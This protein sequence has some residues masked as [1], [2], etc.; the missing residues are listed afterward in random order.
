MEIL[1]SLITIC[2]PVWGLVIIVVALFSRKISL[3]DQ[4]KWLVLPI[5]FIAGMFGYVLEP[6]GEPDLIRYFSQI[7]AI[8]SSGLIELF[9]SDKSYLYIKDALFYFVHKCGN[10]HL[11]PFFVGTFIYGIV[12]YVFTDMIQNSKNSIKKTEIIM[13]SII[14][15]GVIAPYNNIVNVRCILAYSIITYAV[16]RDLIQRKKNICTL[17]LYILPIGLHN[18]AI[19]LLL[20][21]GT[22]WLT[23]RLGR[24]LLLIAFFLPMFI[25]IG[26]R[27]TKYLGHRFLGNLLRSVINKAYYYLNWSEGGW[28]SMIERSI[29]NRLGRIYGVFFIIT[30]LVM[31]W[32]SKDVKKG[33][34]VSLTNYPMT[35]YLI[36]VSACA[37]GCLSIKTGAFWRFESILVLFS[38][39]YLIPLTECKNNIIVKFG[40]NLLYSTSICMFFLNA[41]YQI[42]NLDFYHTMTGFLFTS[43]FQV[44]YEIVKGIV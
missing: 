29:S 5:A 34:E 31:L 22:Y 1:L 41:V 4:G 23:K 14:I 2:Y 3:V 15:I 27:Y 33:D 30:I 24:V 42:R 37:L 38:P 18:S 28:A 16:Y 9:K 21:R 43:G 20:I 26:Y 19:V 40:F 11:L 36:F 35:N 13:M 10:V 39:I 7:N 25:T 17:A 6:I 44:L 8:G 32:G 12:F